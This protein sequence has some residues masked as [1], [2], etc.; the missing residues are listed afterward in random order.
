MNYKT[1]EFKFK[2]ANFL[3]AKY[4]LNG[5][6]KKIL[7]KKKTY[8]TY[9]EW[10]LDRAVSVKELEKQ[11]KMSLKML[12]KPSIE[13][14][15]LPGSDDATDYKAIVSLENQTYSEWKG[16]ILEKE[17]NKKRYNINYENVGDFE[18]MILDKQINISEQIQNI[19][20]ATDADIVLFTRLDQEIEP[21]YLYEMVDN[22]MNETFEVY[23]TDADC[24]KDG[25]HYAPDFKPDYSIDMLRSCNYIGETFAVSKSLLMNA[26]IFYDLKLDRVESNIYSLL[27]QAC[28]SARA[29]KHCPKVLVHSTEKNVD[30]NAVLFEEKAVLERHLERIEQAADVTVNEK[31]KVLDLKYKL[32]EHP[33][34]SILIPNKDQ[35]ETLARCIES[36]EKSTYDNYEVIIIEN[37]ST[38]EKTFEYYE[39]LKKKGI[40]VVVWQSIFNYSAI[41]NFGASYAK[42]EYLVLLNNDIE[43][44]SPD[45]MER[46]LGNCMR[47]GVGIVGAH[48]YYPDKTVQHAGIVVGLGGVAQNLYPGLDGKVG[49]YNNRVFTQQNYSAITAAMCMVSRKIFDSVGGLEE[50]LQVAF[51]DVDFCLKVAKAGY[52]NVYDPNV[53][54]L[55]YESKSRGKEDT[56]EKKLRFAGEI[57]YMQEKW[58]KI[59]IE[60]DPFYN[61]N[62][63][64]ARPDFALDGI[65]KAL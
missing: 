55:H 52:W 44:T 1:L 42:G 19:V 49:G 29:I 47:A 24:I 17:S 11:C 30:I 5:T 32:N 21:N 13:V 6:V 9:N 8:E 62:L 38:D 50:K 20:R 56:P 10:F 48:L 45:W 27:L 39:E 23:Y 65:E 26:E 64:M 14:V 3:Y 53:T 34:V 33:L 12:N 22:Y 36:I 15:I 59:L 25:V 57:A 18:K 4:G 60:G 63:S 37:N 51:N 35:V 28:E 54:A 16:I 61:I 43:I 58:R 7:N 2:K 40:K 31:Y 41:N 46:M